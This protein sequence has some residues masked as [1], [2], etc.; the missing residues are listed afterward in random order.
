[1][2][3]ARRMKLMA[4]PSGLRAATLAR[5]LPHADLREP[6]TDQSE[7]CP[8]ARAGEDARQLRGELDVESDLLA[9]LYGFAERNADHRSIF[10]VFVIRMNKLDLRGQV[11]AARDLHLVDINPTPLAR[12]EF[13][14]SQLAARFIEERA[15]FV[16]ESVEI[17]VKLQVID[18]VRR[19]VEPCQSL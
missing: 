10:G 2:E 3:L 14:A 19:I 15:L 7:G 5:R 9:G 6:L 13:V 16:F 4:V 8:I 11:L 1:V 12:L 17:E 18:R